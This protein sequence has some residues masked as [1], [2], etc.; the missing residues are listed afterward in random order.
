DGRSAVVVDLHEEAP[1]QPTVRP[2]DPTHSRA[3]SLGED[4]DLRLPGAPRIVAEGGK[5]TKGYLYTLESAEL[6]V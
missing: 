5:S 3:D 2:V 4:I 1:C 6:P